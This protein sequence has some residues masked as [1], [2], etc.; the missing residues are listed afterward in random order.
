MT[1]LRFQPDDRSNRERMLA[2]EH[3]LAPETIR[4]T[5]AQY[6]V[7]RSQLT[8]QATDT[9]PTA[10]LTV[11]VTNSGEVLGPMTNNGGG[12]YRAKFNGIANPMNITVTSDSGCERAGAREGEIARPAG[13]GG[14]E[15]G[16]L[17][18]QR[19]TNE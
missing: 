6:T 17:P 10:V 2:G 1:D 8:V 4:I 3:Y 16:G 14:W 13:C 7:A 11:S 9:V 5:R 18:A 15:S 12:N 19:P